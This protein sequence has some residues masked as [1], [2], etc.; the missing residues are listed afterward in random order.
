[1]V[2][3]RDLGRQERA[4]E[5]IRKAFKKSIEKMR[6]PKKGFAQW[7]RDAKAYYRVATLKNGAVD[8]LLRIVN[9]PRDRPASELIFDLG[10][11]GVFKPP[12]RWKLWVSVGF[13]G[14][15]EEPFEA[16]AP[17]PK[18]AAA[19]RRVEKLEAEGFKPLTKQQRY[20]RYAGQSIVRAHSQTGRDLAANI[21]AGQALA[22]ILE[23]KQKKPSQIVFRVYWEP[24]GKRPKRK[25]K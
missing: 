2:S 6:N 23:R 7:M 20:D 11:L 5:A 25:D 4:A 16:D 19:K 8:G 9:L 18:A 14:S 15:F 3:K 22:K 1:L 24:R 10:A 12:G 13:V 17:T 21:L